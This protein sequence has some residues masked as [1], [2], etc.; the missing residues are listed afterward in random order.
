M[1]YYQ[2]LNEALQ[3]PKGRISPLGGLGG[4]LTFS[5]SDRYS[6]KFVVSVHLILFQ[7]G[8]VMILYALTKKGKLFPH[9]KVRVL[10]CDIKVNIWTDIVLVHL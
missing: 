10:G 9:K 7:S 5:F 8:H 4:S 6:P 1:C 2:V 3:N